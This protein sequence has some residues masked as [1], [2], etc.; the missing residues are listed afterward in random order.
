MADE[1]LTFSSPLR[2]KLLR[3]EDSCRKK[4]L[5]LVMSF[6]FSMAFV[7]LLI[8]KEL[9]GMLVMFFLLSMFWILSVIL[10]ALIVNSS[11]TFTSDGIVFKSILGKEYVYS[12]EQIVY[13]KL[14]YFPLRPSRDN[15]KIHTKDK[16]ICFSAS[17]SNFRAARELLKNSS[18]QQ[19]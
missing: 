7:G 10:F 4:I 16:D 3:N 18:L 6:L 13:Y 11:I 8:E 1:N 14:I 17:C 15:F 9:Q 12:Y 19:M 2:D 5:C